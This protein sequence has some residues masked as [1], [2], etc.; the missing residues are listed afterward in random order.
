MTNHSKGR[1]VALSTNK[2]MLPQG[3][4][5][6][7]VSF[8]SKITTRLALS[9][10]TGIY[11]A[12][13]LRCSQEARLLLLAITHPCTPLLSHSCLFLSVCCTGDLLSPRHHLLVPPSLMQRSERIQKAPETDA[14]AGRAERRITTSSST[15]TTL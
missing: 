12:L 2:N 10:Q 15:L 8:Q 11:G 4:M 3:R 9:F 5:Q 13:V 6:K 7:K 14:S 1:M